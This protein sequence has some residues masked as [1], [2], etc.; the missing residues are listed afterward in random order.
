MYKKFEKEVRTSVDSSRTRYY[1]DKFEKHKDDKKQKFNT[2]KSIL[3][4]RNNDVLPDA[5]SDSELCAD[6]EQFFV[7]KIQKIRT[8]ITDDNTLPPVANPILPSACQEAPALDMFSPITH[9]TLY[10][11]LKELS[12][13]HC[14]LD[15]LPANVFKTC[16]EFL[17]S[18]I[19]HIINSSLTTGVFPESF[20]NALV[21]PVLKNSNLDKETLS[22]YRPISNLS[23]FSKLLEKCVLKQLI[24][25]LDTYDLLGNCQSGYRKHHSCESALI[26]VTNDI[27]NNLD[28]NKSTYVI[29]LDLRAAFDTVDHDLLIERLEKQFRI[30]GTALKWFKSYLSNRCFNVKIR[31]S[32]SNGV[33]IFYGVPQGSIL[34]PILFLLYISDIERIAL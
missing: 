6:L 26:K 27:L 11:V 18:Y 5:D 33:I 23:L 30:T 22:S 14:D 20:K 8:G 10:S 17:A 9:E 31:V 25:H 32:M 15:I 24:S 19:L 13:K 2:L 28:C 4:K 1:V 21:R 7:G 29:M 16:S 12:N 34:G 3:G